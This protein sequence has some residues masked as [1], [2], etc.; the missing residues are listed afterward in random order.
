MDSATMMAGA[1]DGGA[2][3]LSL[4]ADLL[5]L[6]APKRARNRNPPVMA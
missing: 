6:I 5:A 3:E 2:G 1:R 4:P